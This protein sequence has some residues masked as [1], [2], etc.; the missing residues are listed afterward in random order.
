MNRSELAKM[1]NRDEGAGLKNFREAD[2][3]VDAFIEIVAEG[4]VED[5]VMKIPDFG[6]VKVVQHEPRVG[7]NPRTGERLQI[8]ARKHLKF[9]PSKILLESLS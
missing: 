8:G 4:L 5:G 3:V 9:S 6:T 7:R 2:R 1:L